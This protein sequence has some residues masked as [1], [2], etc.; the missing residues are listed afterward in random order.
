MTSCE[1][2]SYSPNGIIVNNSVN[3]SVN[4]FEEAISNRTQTL[5]FPANTG[6]VCKFSDEGV[7]ICL[8]TDCFLLNGEPVASGDIILEYIEIFDKG[9]MVVTN[10]ATTDAGTGE[11]LISGG[12]F[13]VQAYMNG[14][15]LSIS[16]NCDWAGLL[17]IDPNLTGGIDWEMD[18]WMGDINED[19][20]LN[21]SPVIDPNF[22]DTINVVNCSFQDEVCQYTLPFLWGWHNCDVFYSWPSPK[23]TVTVNIPSEYD[24]SNSQV[25]IL[26]DAED[27]GVAYF[28]YG[29]ANFFQSYDSTIPVGMDAHILFVLAYGN[30]SFSYAIESLTIEAGQVITFSSMD[31]ETATESEMV[32]LINLLP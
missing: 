22:G 13:Y 25:F 1:Q 12:E 26:Y 6:T 7:Q 20:N 31:L 23:T 19:G 9:D 14:S 4:L 10:K 28:N 32:D 17:N 16:T 2:N 5:V 24:G 15:E 29:G 21:W 11:M 30:G 8:E 18:M 27:G 3:S